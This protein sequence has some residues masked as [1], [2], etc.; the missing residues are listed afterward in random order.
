MRLSFLS[1]HLL[2][3]TCSCVYAV[4]QFA[5]S[6]YI[7]PKAVKDPC[8][9]KVCRFGARC[10]PAMDGR[11]AECTCPDKCPSYGDHR[12]SLPVCATDGK[13]YP[14]VCELRRAACQNMKDVEERY[15]GKCGE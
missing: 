7:F 1:H 6:C 15:Q 11:T 13:D 9:N 3:L 5:H 4:L 8:E 2:L 14:N 12:G 10:V